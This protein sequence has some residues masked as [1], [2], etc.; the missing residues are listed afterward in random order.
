[1]A[2]QDKMKTKQIPQA[3]HW[4]L[5]DKAVRE[6]SSTSVTSASKQDRRASRHKQP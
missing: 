5:E 4:T 1:M 6:V 2:A 3:R